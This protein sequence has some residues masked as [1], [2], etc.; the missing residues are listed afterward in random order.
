[1]NTERA[2]A[3]VRR[4]SS[5]QP[6]PGADLIELAIIDGWQCVVGKD[7]GHKVGDL[8]IYMEIDAFLPATDARYESFRPRFIQWNG[9]EGLR[10][11]T[12]RLRKQLSQGVVLPVREFPELKNPSEGQNVTELLKIEK[13]ESAEEMGMN[14]SLKAGK[15]AGAFPTFI[16]KTNQERAQNSTAQLH[17]AYDTEELFER[18]IKLHGSSMTVYKVEPS[19]PHYKEALAIQKAG[20]KK[21][22]RPLTGFAKL[23]A[24]VKE[25]YNDIFNK[26]PPTDVF[27][28]CSRNISIKP[29]DDSDFNK[30]AQQQDLF[31]DLAELNGSY[32]F[33]GEIIGPNIQQGF[34]KAQ[35]LEFR[36]FDIYDIDEGRYLLPGERKA[37]ADELM[38]LTAPTDA[39]LTLK[40]V[41]DRETIVNDLLA[42]AE[43]PGMNPGVKREG[44]V[45]KSMS[46]DFS[47]KVVATSFLERKGAE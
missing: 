4:I 6:I 17:T 14:G 29:G 23:V 27:G 21:G 2:L 20:L 16:P 18:T 42:A 31:G 25:W 40:D 45:Y 13:W 33:Q 15:A 36:L 30:V 5:L 11:K 19:S 10:V 8:V 38:I 28:V 9:K 12:I 44:H 41:G 43:G 26:Q 35:T 24:K 37:L 34:E 46:R 7:V 47:F 22:G 39:I 32:A 3:S 1:M